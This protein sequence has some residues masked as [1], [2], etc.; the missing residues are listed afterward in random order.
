M[1]LFLLRG[2]LHAAL[3]SGRARGLPVPRPP[4]RLLRLVCLRT[5]ARQARG[6][7]LPGHSWRGAISW[8]FVSRPWRRVC[9]RP[10][11]NSCCCWDEVCSG[12]YEVDW[13]L[14]L[15]WGFNCLLWAQRLVLA[16]ALASRPPLPLTP[17]GPVASGSGGGGRCARCHT[18]RRFGQEDGGRAD[19]TLSPPARQ[20]L[21]RQD[22]V[23]VP[24][25][26][27]GLPGRV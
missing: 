8:A 13:K 23:L 19:D 24:Q 18:R 3:R 5:A 2:H 26:G 17:L 25:C 12:L 11:K 27:R 1:V 4:R 22:H 15:G 14:R 9:S 16:A 20:G 6:V 7:R 21:W 10:L